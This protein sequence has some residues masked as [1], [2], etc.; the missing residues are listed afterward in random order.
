M[1]IMSLIG[2]AHPSFGKPFTGKRK[3]CGGKCRCGRELVVPRPGGV[4]SE[5]GKEGAEAGGV[6]E[7]GKLCGGTGLAG[8]VLVRTGRRTAVMVED[9][10][11]DC[12]WGFIL[13]D[14]E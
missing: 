5:P 13:F 4:L 12:Y 11:S 9:F 6:R 1:S 10:M 2:D 7:D 3:S 8:G 14:L